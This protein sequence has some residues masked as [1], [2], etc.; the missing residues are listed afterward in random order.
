MASRIKIKSFNKMI[1][2]CHFPS[3]QR[4]LTPSAFVL[5]GHR[6]FAY[7]IFPASSCL[8]PRHVFSL[9]LSLTLLIYGPSVVRKA[10]G[11]LLCSSSPG[12]SSPLLSPPSLFEMHLWCPFLKRAH[13]PPPQLASL[14]SCQ[15]RILWD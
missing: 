11:S 2:S 1:C 15:L 9:P 8:V 12:P 7:T 10:Q 6:T 14:P 5:F 4:H 13:L 3:D